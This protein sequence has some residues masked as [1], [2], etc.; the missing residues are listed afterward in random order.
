[1]AGITKISGDR[2]AGD[3]AYDEITATNVEKVQFSDQTIT[4]ATNEN[5]IILPSNLDN[6]AGTSKDDTVHSLGSTQDLNGGEGHDSLIV[7]GNSSDFQITRLVDNSTLLSPEDQFEK[8]SWGEKHLTGFENIIFLDGNFDI[9][10]TGIELN[11]PVK[12]IV[13]GGLNISASL[14]LT[15]VPENTV[16]I[17][18]EN[19]SLLNYSSSSF[20]FTTENW[21]EFQSFTISAPDNNLID[22]VNTTEIMG[23]I[24]SEDS[25][26]NNLDFP[27]VI[28]DFLDND[29]P[30]VG[31]ITGSV[32]Y[33]TDR[34]GVKDNGE[35]ATDLGLVY[36]DLNK[37][38]TRDDEEPNHAV[39]A[40]GTYSFSNLAP[41]T[42][43]VGMDL[44]SG[45]SAT[46]PNGAPASQ[47]S[48]ISNS[49]L[50][51]VTFEG[52]DQEYHSKYTEQVS[53]H[54]I[55]SDFGYDGSGQ[56]VVVMD[57]G[58][59]LDH[60]FF[61]EDSDG[62]GVADKIIF[63]KDFTNEQD[64]TADDGNG[65]GTHVAGII[66]SS[67]QIYPGVAPGASLIGLQ[68]L[69]ASGRGS[70]AGLEKALTWCI[71]NVE[72]YNISVINMSLGFGDNSTEPKE[73]MLTDELAA[74]NQLGVTVVSSSGN[75][76]KDY[77]TDGVGYPSSDPGSMSVGAVFH[78]D[79]GS[80][81]GA[82]S[83]VADQIAPF[84]Q[85]DPD[86]T[87]IMAP[88]V[89]IPS[90]W[91]NDGLKSI[92]GT[93]MAAP[94]VAG[95]VAVLQ[96]AAE[97]ILG[98]KL[99]SYE[100]QDLFDEYSDTIFDGDDEDDGLNHT[101]SDYPRLNLDSLIQ[102]IEYMKK[103]G[104]H[105][106]DVTAGK[107]ES[108]DFGVAEVLAPEQGQS[109]SIL[110]IG[111]SYSDELSGS[112][113]NDFLISGAGND[114]IFGRGGAD[115]ILAGDGNDSIFVSGSG[116]K[117][118]TGSGND[119][120][121]FNVDAKNIEISDFEVSNPTMVTNKITQGTSGD[122]ILVSTS[123]T[124]DLILGG[125][126][127]DTIYGFAHS[128]ILVGGAGNDIIFGG[129]GD[130][131]M[132][133]SL[134][135]DTLEGG[136]GVDFFIFDVRNLSQEGNN[137]H[138]ILDF[139]F[140]SDQLG[141]LNSTFLEAPEIISENNKLSIKYK[142]NVIVDLS[143]STSS[144]IDGFEVLLLSERVFDDYETLFSTEII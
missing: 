102:A 74:L 33:D 79:V 106:F 49:D 100:V 142:D 80:K 13:E 41:G 12:T 95:A 143:V 64:N 116:S 114:L 61:G 144:N 19:N 11:I 23:T 127:N 31:S 20:S 69:T 141:L 60:S 71:E 72:E 28:L 32:W 47:T 122:D 98:R 128:D 138:K 22:G 131:I 135:K 3:Y 108:G 67:D 112:T 30:T 25:D 65:H 109:D 29:I 73:W 99:M 133:A 15:K 139:D 123:E 42:Y 46:H 90:A 63:S 115:T 68:V 16:K 36:I 4:L 91:L 136:G 124:I 39:N 96:Q 66:G 120:V 87:S 45:F 7:F 89:L 8:Y 101:N 84:S 126:G 50:S 111:S 34:D 56:C 110:L 37:D 103:P 130:D 129:G 55:K 85:R 51:G 134:G 78:S 105:K 137:Q 38:G 83:S 113:S 17:N 21:S 54:N 6:W 44:P 77:Q 76:Y 121:F 119:T 107:E 14:R 26:Y 57:T 48:V 118:K 5:S 88:G 40:D 92:S 10:Y 93:S 97:N 59:D 81:Y 35:S 9:S 117:I 62:N 86:Q 132:V 24:S 27:S 75:S 1:M 43:F 58:I 94:V 140:A 2:Y 53:S 18:I 70:G 82:S 125:D 104:F 52:T